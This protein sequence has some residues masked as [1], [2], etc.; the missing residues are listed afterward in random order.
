[1]APSSRAS[2]A[3]DRDAAKVRRQ[4][5]FIAAGGVLLLGILGF[6]FRGMVLGSGSGSSSSAAATLP[7]AAVPQ[8]TPVVPAAAP[9][10]SHGKPRDLFVPGIADKNASQATT[11]TTTPTPPPVRAS[12]FVN[13]DVFIPQIVMAT[14][15][16]AAPAVPALGG[17]ASG[18]TP[19]A[20]GPG[21]TYVVVLG[22][23]PGVG[24]ASLKA[25]ARAIVAA[26]NA[27]LKDVTANNNIP[28]TTKQGQH[29]TVFTGPYLEKSTADSELVRALRNGYPTARSQLVP[30]PMSGGFLPPEAP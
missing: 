24:P 9:A 15:P 28:G 26:K 18:G 29:Y 7:P 21:S 23:I 10:V 1:M 17:A 11:T 25:A 12:N 3:D 14:A 27:G 5:I 4:K 2:R 8:A 19:A 30:G 22:I 13:K 20:P 6:Q 16:T